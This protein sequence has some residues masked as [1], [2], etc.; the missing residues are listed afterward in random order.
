MYSIVGFEPISLSDFP[1]RTSCV[2]FIGGCNY[3]C[4]TCHNWEVATRTGKFLKPMSLKETCL[5]IYENRKF[6]SGVC[7]TG[8]EPLIAP[9]IVE[10]VKEIS[11]LKPVKVDTNG[12]RAGV[13]EQLLPL[14]DLFAVDIKAPI[15]RYNEFIGI[16]QNELVTRQSLLNIRRLSISYPEKFY[17]RTTVVP[18]IKEEDIKKIKKFIYPN[19]LHLQE[20]RIPKEHV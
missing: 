4:P 8:G 3:K 7:I 15:E 12:T 11:Y 13:V 19:E 14:V 18:G 1:G 5:K 9:D 17:F 6:I 16:F 2:V 20:Y 10:I